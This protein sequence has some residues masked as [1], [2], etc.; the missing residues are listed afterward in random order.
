MCMRRTTNVILTCLISVFVAQFVGVM[1]ASA[2]VD[3]TVQHRKIAILA[4]LYLD[5]AFDASGNYRYG[6]VLPKYIAPGLEF[7]QGVQLAIDSLRS[8]GLKLEINIFD[9]RAGKAALQDIV[10]KPEFD[11][12]EVM[13]AHVNMADAQWLAQTAKSRSIPLVNVNFPNEAG[14]S[15]NPQYIILNSTLF[16]HCEGLYR[17]MQKNYALSPIVVFRRKGAQEDR[18]NAYLKEI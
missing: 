1:N 6:K 17:F 5:S 2:Q 11:G 12:T 8:E 18:L 7:Y 16:T 9:T 13:I 10:S 3:S 14:V 4:P 15:D